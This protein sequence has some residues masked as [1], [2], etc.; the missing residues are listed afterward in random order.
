MIESKISGIPCLIKVTHC[1]IVPGTFSYHA[2]SDLDYHGYSD[3]DFEV[4]DQHGR[5]APW[6]EK[7]MTDKDIERICQEIEEAQHLL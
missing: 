5:P 7:K 3:I 4:C 2:G 1:H 6:L